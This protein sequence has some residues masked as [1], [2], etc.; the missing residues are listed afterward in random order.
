MPGVPKLDAFL[1]GCSYDKAKRYCLNLQSD[2][3]TLSGQ[4]FDHEKFE[5]CPEHGVRKYGWASPTV[6]TVN[7]DKIDWSNMGSRNKQLRINPTVEMDTRDTRDPQ[8]IGLKIL[9][10]KNGRSN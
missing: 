4:R 2:G 5:V 3:I 7:G 6:S 10:T 9:A 1:C 8:K